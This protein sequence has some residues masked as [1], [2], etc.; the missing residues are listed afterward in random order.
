MLL[1]ATSSCD[2]TEVAPEAAA[3][4]QAASPGTSP[5]AQGK[6]ITSTVSGTYPFT[7]V[8]NQGQTVTENRQLQNGLLRITNFMVQNGTIYAIGMVSGST[9]D[10]GTGNLPVQIPLALS[11]LSSSCS[12]LTINY[13]PMSFNL[14]GA[15]ISTSSNPTLRVTPEQSSKNLLG[16]MLCSL[17]VLLRNPSS[18]D[19]DGVVSH[20][21]KI[22]SQVDYP[23]PRSSY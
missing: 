21:N 6:A 10:F 12:A 9:A 13:G 1:A 20:L 17:G 15:A 23:T 2:K 5:L 8:N 18:A 4:E 7:Y 16:N 14:N 22:I 11:Q 3:V 19:A